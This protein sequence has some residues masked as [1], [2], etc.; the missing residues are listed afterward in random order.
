MEYQALVLEF[1]KI[2]IAQNDWKSRQA[3]IKGFS[4][5]LYG[6][7][8]EQNQT[9][10]SSSINELIGLLNDNSKQVQ[11]ATMES[12]IIITEVCGKFILT[13][14]LFVEYLKLIL[15]KLS[16]S[17]KFLKSGCR[18]VDNLCEAE[19]DFKLGKFT[20]ISDDLIGLFLKYAVSSETSLAV[21]SWSTTTIMNI[22]EVTQNPT[23]ILKYLGFVLENFDNLSQIK[24]KEKRETIT[25]AF[26]TFMQFCLHGLKKTLLDQNVIMSVYNKVT[27]YFKAIKDV[28]ADGFYA[29]EALVS[30]FNGNTG[31]VDDF[32]PYITHALQKLQDPVLFRATVSCL[33]SFV[34]SYG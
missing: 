3:S 2:S 18:I 32:W 5:L 24:E 34:V 8:D 6:L 22:L 28:N 10:I 26:F 29:I 1:V 23:V 14:P 4:L 25:S 31:L 15:S 19:K 30:F 27:N 21:I 20:A 33:A 12:L 17:E 9:L 16:L 13:S 7:S 11:Y